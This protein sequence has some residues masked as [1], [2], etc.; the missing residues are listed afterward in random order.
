MWKTWVQSLGQEDPLEKKLAT[1]SS[2]PAWKIPWTEKPG[3]LHTGS[4]R[5]RHDWAT[6]LSVTFWA[7]QVALV[8][9]NPP[10]STE[11]T[12]S[13]LGWKDPLEN[14]MNNE[15]WQATWS[16]G[17]QRF[18]SWLKWPSTHAVT[19]WHFSGC[20]KVKNLSAVQET[21]FWSLGWEYLLE[22]GMAIHSSI[23]A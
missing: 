2:I 23:L 10:A 1:H 7:S 20:T 19:Y 16:I 11:D 14:P 12:G 3:G 17:S 8:E 15:T 5:V 18:E 22:K 21:W 9:K 6:S 4:Q 13:S